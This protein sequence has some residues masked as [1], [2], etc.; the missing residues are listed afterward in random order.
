MS[1]TKR[2]FAGSTLFQTTVVTTE[3]YMALAGVMAE[4]GET[5]RAI[6]LQ[7]EFIDDLLAARR[8]H[9]LCQPQIRC[10]RAG[11]LRK[12]TGFSEIVDTR[13]NQLMDDLK[14]VG[15]EG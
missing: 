8:L 2:K 10:T 7:L 3:E 4:K 14:A 5:P 12:K 11:V 9:T 6:N 1:M 15:S 13:L